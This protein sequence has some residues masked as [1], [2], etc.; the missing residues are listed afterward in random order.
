MEGETSEMN[1]IC[2]HVCKSCY[3][4]VVCAIHAVVERPDAVLLDANRC[5]GC[6][7]CMT[8]CRSFGH[9]MIRYKSLRTE[10]I[11]PLPG[12]PAPPWPEE[13]EPE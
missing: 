4:K 13:S 2:T 5:I 9:S 3:A 8:A 7:C 10:R 1:V 11:K 12:A 6:G